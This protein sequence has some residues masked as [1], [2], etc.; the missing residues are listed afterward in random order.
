MK[1]SVT[2]R[3]NQDLFVTVGIIAAVFIAAGVIMQLRW[4]N[5]RYRQVSL[6]LDTLAAREHDNIAN[7]LFERRVQALDMRLTEM[8]NVE[9]VLRV[10]LYDGQ[11][12]PLTSASHG[13]IAEGQAKDITAIKPETLEF[14]GHYK[15]EHDWRTMRFV[16]PITALGEVMGWLEIRYDL[17]M[18]R[19]QLIEFFLFYLTLL[20]IILLCMLIILRRRLD[21]SLI[22]PL[23]DLGMAMEAL[24]TA[25]SS[26][27][28]DPLGASLQNAD[29][30]VAHLWTNF[31][32]MACRLKASYLDLAKASR[33]IQESERRFKSIFDN[34]PYAI[35][36]SSLSDG[37]YIDVNN[38]F[39]KSKGLNKEQALAL[40]PRKTSRKSPDHLELFR[41]QI[42]QGGIFN[43][44]GQSEL[45]DGSI[46]DVLFSAVPIPYGDEEAILSMVVDITDKKRT[47]EALR[48]SEAMSTAMFNQAF[49]FFGLLDLDGRIL[50][51]NNSAS[52]ELK[53]DQELTGQSFWDAPWWPDREE[54]HQIGDEA[55]R[56]AKKGEIY[57]KEVQHINRAGKIHHIDLAFSPLKD[58][59]GKVI[60]LIPEGRDITDRKR[61]ED[62][63]RQS[64]ELLRESGRIA[65]VGGWSADI[66]KGTV[67]WSPE[68]KTIHEVEPDF[69]PSY[70][71]NRNFAAPEWQDKVLKSYRRCIQYGGSLDEEFE[72]I[73]AKGNR[74]WVRT[75]GEAVKDS[76]GKIIRVI[77]ALQDIS[78]RKKTEE[79]KKKLQEH[80][81]QARKMEAIGILA[82]GIAHD[83]NNILSGLMGFTDLA[84]LEAGDND[85]LKKY[86]TQVSSSSLRARDLVRHILT[87]SRKSDAD[88]Q[89]LMINPIIKETI[90]FIRASLPAN[91]E[92]KQD[93]RIDEGH[94]FGDATQIHQ[95]LMN[96]F[97]NAGHAMKDAGG[98]LEVTLDIVTLEEN[99]TGYF[100]KTPPGNYLR[101]SISDTG[102]GIPKKIIDRIFEPFFTTKEREEG[103]GMGL[104]TVYGILKEMG[105]G[106]SVYSEEGAGTTFKI[107]MPEH[108]Q[109][110]ASQTYGEPILK[111]GQG[112]ILIVDDEKDI[113]ESTC[114]LLSRLGYSATG[115][116]NGIK[117]AEIV[118]KDPNFYDLILTDMTM[119]LIN[120]LDLAKKIR[121]IN[122][123]IPIV[124]C[125]GFSHGVTEEKCANA[126]ITKMIM[127]PLIFSE[128]SL[129]IH[130]AIN[131]K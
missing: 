36:I 20:V 127:K 76:S 91:I 130:K 84:M 58:D 124:L 83:F 107:L 118:R 59:T 126:G 60:Y 48:Q 88:K 10:T 42:C 18:L 122:P 2:R 102:C 25:E 87:F 69:S 29:R 81:N 39:L 24:Q 90:K 49:N 101:L 53:S 125:T 77:G 14:E 7:E 70:D 56:T 73:T 106:I 4:N 94:I 97:T 99:Q 9:D 112:N 5:E 114:E 129:T 74:R 72:I 47:E 61:M 116:T 100:G 54:A 71:G 23:K 67:M 113:V 117:A 98:V 52:N 79:E 28:W 104:A 63:L 35:F 37:R 15:A 6:L 108:N 8:S 128:L 12:Q 16:R 95:I 89:P 40:S 57:R 17:S 46:A 121:E 34:A 96:L 82:G 33:N 80:L 123:D 86:L 45:H 43:V 62:D 31:Q 21:T 93:L 26:G 115:E 32:D 120:G 103:T 66:E 41:E 27:S 65:R 3:L 75:T 78:D 131:K 51:I 64:A 44:E 55:I 13:R 109:S 92:I 119:P 1:R 85:A 19:K 68:M 111:T 22:R 105:G 30:E 11:G 38:T 110:T 50:K